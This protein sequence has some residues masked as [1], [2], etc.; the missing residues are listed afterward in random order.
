MYFGPTADEAHRFVAGLTGWMLAGL[1]DAGR[2]RALDD[3]HARMVAHES[4]RGV[5]F[6]SAMWLVTATREK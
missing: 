2:R 1:D 4:S 5:E 6:G 3:L